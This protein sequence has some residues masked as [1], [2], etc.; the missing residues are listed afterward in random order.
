MNQEQF[1]A[2][3]DEKVRE[4]DIDA[5]SVARDLWMAGFRVRRPGW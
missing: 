3:L 2:W 5:A 1:A 4:G